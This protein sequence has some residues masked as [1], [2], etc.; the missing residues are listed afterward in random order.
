MANRSDLRGYV[1]NY[2]YEASADL[3]ADAKINQALDEAMTELN[4]DGVY[5][6]AIFENTLVV[7]QLDYALPTGTVEVESIEMNVGTSDNPEWKT[8]HGWEVYAG[9]YWLSVRPATTNT[10]RLKVRK[11]FTLLTDDVTATDV[12]TDKI[13][14]LTCLASIKCYEMLMGYFVDAKNW[15]S[16]AKPDSVDMTKVIAWIRELNTKYQRMRMKFRETPKAQDINLV[17]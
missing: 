6:Q 17:E 4:V 11:R 5:T 14:I 13:P 7:N 16:I 3:F 12:P 8:M 9:A 2:L 1:R 10:V 15:D